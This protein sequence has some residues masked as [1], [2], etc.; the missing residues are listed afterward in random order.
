MHFTSSQIYC[1]DSL[2]AF[3]FFLL[4][5]KL[6]VIFFLTNTEVNGRNSS[7]FIKG[8]EIQTVIKNIECQMNHFSK[9]L[10]RSNMICKLV[11]Q[12]GI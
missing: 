1:Y 6:M 8:K 5:T 10:K 7:G 11:S 4:Q 9:L 2:Y 12:V 3:F